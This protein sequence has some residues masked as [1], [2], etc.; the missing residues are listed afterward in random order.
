MASSI[1]TQARLQYLFTYDGATGVFTRN[2]DC[3]NTKA[4]TSAGSPSNKGYMRI[5]VDN[6]RYLSHR[7]AWLYV[8]GEFPKDQLDHING[9]KSDNRIANLR[10]ATNKENFQNFKDRNGKLGTYYHKLTGKWGAQIGKDYQR[11]HL[12]LFDSQEEAHNAYKKAK[13]QLHEFQPTLIVLSS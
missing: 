10:L 11:W 6:R 7:L 12:G 9:V 8:H 1:L 4:G 5:M 2:V 13:Q 3:N